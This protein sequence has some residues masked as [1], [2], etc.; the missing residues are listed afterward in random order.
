MMRILHLSPQVTLGGAGQAL[1]GLAAAGGGR[2]RHA[3]VSVEPPDPRAVA[4]AQAAG[5]EIVDPSSAAQ[6]AARAD[7]LQIEFWSTPAFRAFLGSFHVPRRQVLWAHV[8]GFT[9]PQVLTPDLVRSSAF[10]V[11]SDPSSLAIPELEGHASANR[12]R[13]IPAGVRI[14]RLAGVTEPPATPPL[15]VGYLGSVDFGKLHERFVAMS[16]AAPSDVRFVVAGAGPDLPALRREIRKRRLGERFECLGFLTQPRD[17]L[18]RIH[19]LGHPIA[20]ESSAAAELAIQEAMFVARPPVVLEGAGGSHL[21][22]HERTGLVAPDPVEYAGCLE[23]LRDPALRRRLGEAARETAATRYTAARCAAGFHRLYEEA[24]DSPRIAP[25]IAVPSPSPSRAFVE[26]LGLLGRDFQTSLEG[27]RPAEAADA[28]IAASSPCLA[29][30][31]NG[32]IVH[33]RL[34]YPGDGHLR[35]W[36]GLVFETR[37]R[38]ALAAAEFAAAEELLPRDPRPG[39]YRRRVER[40]AVA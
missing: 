11:V 3:V 22:A 24:A 32:G 19:V 1:L 27:G 2:F 10:I 39:A 38:R 5:L 16:A 30:G 37:G 20:P 33:Y 6:A 25:T 8:R 4:E 29:G 18:S 7:I 14:E 28:R 9:A 23:R 35:L 17:A 40:A 34:A 36:A 12:A 21:V 31:G 15:S 26:A 13:C